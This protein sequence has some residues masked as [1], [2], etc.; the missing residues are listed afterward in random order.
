MGVLTDFDM[1]RDLIRSAFVTVLVV[2]FGAF[3]TACAC[4]H[5]PAEHLAVHGDM[6]SM[7]STHDATMQAHHMNHAMP[8]AGEMDHG[9]TSETCVDT[10][11]T[12]GHTPSVDAVTSASKAPAYVASIAAPVV[13]QIPGIQPVRYMSA[14]RLN[15]APPRRKPDRASPTPLMMKVRFLT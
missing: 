1:M 11:G 7:A 6:S 10:T 8:M 3:Q 5:D 13:Y 4:A 2:L 15:A 12:C 9:S 14:D